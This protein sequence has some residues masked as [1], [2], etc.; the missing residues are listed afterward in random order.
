MA[1]EEE[2]HVSAPRATDLAEMIGGIPMLRVV[3]SSIGIAG[4]L[5]ASGFLVATGRQSLLGIPIPGTEGVA[6]YAATAGEFLAFTL[7]LFWR[8]LPITLGGV[9]VI[10]I[11]A[12]V[13][14]ATRYNVWGSIGARK[15]SAG[16]LGLILA[17]SIKGYLL[18][19]PYVSMPDLLDQPPMCRAATLYGEQLRQREAWQRVLYSRNDPTLN[20]LLGWDAGSSQS[21][22]DSAGPRF[23]KLDQ[24]FL[25]DL[26]VTAFLSFLA[27]L[28][29]VARAI[30]TVYSRNAVA[31]LRLSL[32]IIV[33]INLL[34]LPFIYGKV[35]RS[36]RFPQG[37]VIVD[38]IDPQSPSIK[39]LTALLVAGSDKFVTLYD[40]EGQQYLQVDR[41]HVRWLSLKTVDDIVARRTVFNLQKSNCQ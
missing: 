26:I 23:L 18:D 25:I 24:E 5:T 15:W 21:V 31:L 19:Y 12:A 29:Y 7:G 27:L 38:G 2:A 6:D 1:I 14:N 17:F 20:S 22:R 4:L 11:A 40:L 8:Y 33:V 41:K 35:V 34:I 36:T 28:L 16:L 10:I 3:L 13:A 37:Q 30:D 39:S 9:V 32:V